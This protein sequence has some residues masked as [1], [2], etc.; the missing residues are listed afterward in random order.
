VV[1]GEHLWVF[2]EDADGVEQKVAEIDGVECGEARLVDLVQFLALALGKLAGLV[3]RKFLRPD[4]AVLPA[5]DEGGEIARRPACLVDAL[6]FQDLLDQAQ[7]VIGV[8]HG[9]AGL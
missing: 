7:L 1:V 5:I 2:G 3:V 9:E 6:G 8:E 4:G